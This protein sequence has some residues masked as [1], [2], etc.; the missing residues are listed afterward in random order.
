MGQ[1]DDQLLAH[2]NDVI[3]TVAYR[4]HKRYRTYVDVSDVRQECLEW[5]LKRPDKIEQWLM[6]GQEKENLERGIRALAK[7]LSRHADRFC[8]KTK[9]C[10]PDMNYAMK[11]IT[12]PN[13]L[14]NSCPTCGLLS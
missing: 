3:A 13:L 12:L 6:P 9:A 8:R 7:T 5:C 11:R 2:A 1:I 14:V 4:V 10:L